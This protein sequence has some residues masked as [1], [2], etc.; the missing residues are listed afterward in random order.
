[1]AGA[2]VIKQISPTK[3]KEDAMRLAMLNPLHK[4]AREMLAD[5]EKTTESWEHKVE[6]KVAVSLALGGPSVHITTDDEIYGYVN[7]GTDPHLIWAGAYTGLSNKKALSFRW[8]GKGSYKAKTTPRKIGSQP[9]GP[10]GPRVAMPYVQHPGT[11]ARKFD[12]EIQ[13]LWEP[14]FKRRME[15][16]MSDVA[17]ASGHEM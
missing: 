7:N 8:G 10:T 14:K 13:K 11:K 2:I 4:V 12:E 3:L 1:M 9:G 15:Q 5:F 16:V 17:Q 6:F